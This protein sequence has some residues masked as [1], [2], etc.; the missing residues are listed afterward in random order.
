MDRGMWQEWGQGCGRVE[1]HVVGV[2][3]GYGGMCQGWGMW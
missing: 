1:G 3:A 2:V